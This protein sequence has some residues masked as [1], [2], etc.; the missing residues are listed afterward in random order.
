MASKTFVHDILRGIHVYSWSPSRVSMIFSVEF[1][2][3]HGLQVACSWY[4]VWNSRL[5]MVSKS[6]IH[7]I[8]CGIHVYS[9]SRSHWFMIFSMEFT[10]IHGLEVIGSWYSVWNSRL[11]MV[12]KSLVRDI[13]CG[14]HI[15]SWSPSHWFM[16]EFTF[17]HGLQVIGSW[18][19]VWNSHLFMVSKSLVHDIQCEIHVYSWSPSHWFVIFSVEFTFIH[20]LEVIGSWYSVWNSHLFMV[21]KSLVHDIQCG[22]HVYSWSRSHWFVI[23]SVEFTFIH[24]LQVIGSCVNSHLFMASKSLVHDI[25]C[26]I[27]IYSWSRSHWFMIFSVEF[28]FIHGVQVTGLWYSVWNSRLFMVSKSL[29][30]RSMKR[31]LLHSCSHYAISSPCVHPVHST[32]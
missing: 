9:G 21:S 8:Q 11:F 27:H 4:S 25:Q 6:L 3:I 1:T 2:F 30:L 23:F 5:F 28:T 22:I 7:D 29:L 16:C 24:G 20:G 18:Y 12:S 10:F 13:Q 26:G 15:Y 31:K 32:S 17:I 19:S 14:I